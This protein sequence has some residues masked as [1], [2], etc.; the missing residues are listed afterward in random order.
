MSTTIRLV[1]ELED[2]NVRMD[3][4]AGREQAGSLAW[5]DEVRWTTKQ[6]VAACLWSTLF[7]LGCGYG[8]L[9]L[10]LGTATCR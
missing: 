3:C 8:W 7:G 1:N 9:L 2:E 5:L 10:Q 6:V 4:V